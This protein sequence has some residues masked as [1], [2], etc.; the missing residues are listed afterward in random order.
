MNPRFIVVCNGH[1]QEKDFSPVE[2]QGWL[3]TVIFDMMAYESGDAM[4]I[5]ITRVDEDA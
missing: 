4:E 5:V 3:S 1:E 2:L